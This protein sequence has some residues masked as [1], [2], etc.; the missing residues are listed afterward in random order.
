VRIL[1]VQELGPLVSQIAVSILPLYSSCAEQIRS[2]LYYIVVDNADALKDHLKDL[3][4]LPELPG[5]FY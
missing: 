3:H 5:L 2:I 1:G 4:F